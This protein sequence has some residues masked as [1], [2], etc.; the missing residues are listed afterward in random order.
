MQLVDLTT[1]NPSNK[2]ERDSESGSPGSY[3]TKKLLLLVL[4]QGIIENDQELIEIAHDIGTHWYEIGISLGLSRNSMETIKAD[5][6]IA[7]AV[8]KA[9]NMLQQWKQQATDGCSYQELSTALTNV[10][11]YSIA[12]KHCFETKIVK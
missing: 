4:K 9:L 2:R 12:A 8:D 5:Y 3:S 11:M 1:T 7:T 10:D 6:S